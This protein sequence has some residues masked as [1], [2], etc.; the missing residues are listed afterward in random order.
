VRVLHIKTSE[1]NW[2]PLF[3]D[4]GVP[5]HPE[6]M[7]ELD[8]TWPSP[9]AW[10]ARASMPYPMRRSVRRSTIPNQS[11]CFGHLGKAPLEPLERLAFES[12]SDFAQHIDPPRRLAGREARRRGRSGRVPG[13]G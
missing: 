5:L 1:E 9:I 4:K 2:I 3:D 10:V 11:C 8:A 6:L 7:A 12:A 13:R